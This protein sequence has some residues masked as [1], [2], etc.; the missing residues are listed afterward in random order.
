MGGLGSKHVDEVIN[1]TS[2]IEGTPKLTHILKIDPRSPS[3][4]ITRTP[5]AV[6][7][8]PNK[9]PEQTPCGGK[10]LTTLPDDPRSPTIEVDRTP[11]HIETKDKQK[12]SVAMRPSRLT[13]LDST[14]SVSSEASGTSE[15][16]NSSSSS[17]SDES[18]PR[19]PTSKVPRTP[20]ENKEHVFSEPEEIMDED[21]GCK[22]LELT[23]VTDKT[24]EST[25]DKDSSTEK[26]GQV[27]QLDNTTD[28]FQIRRPL[29]SLQNNGTSSTPRGILQAKQCRNVEDEYNKSQHTI[30]TQLTGQVKK[31]ASNT[32]FVENI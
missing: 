5:I 29:G 4:Y 25:F 13:Q 31:V 20:L 27:F 17:S 24:D 12:R 21:T 2:D 3:D 30:M 8:T 23:E 14:S 16:N 19:S 22:E 10:L 32:Q 1:D 15:A 26:K 9:N 7:N 11:I 6:S 18:D 28:K